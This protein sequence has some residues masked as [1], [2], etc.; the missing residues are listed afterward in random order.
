MVHIKSEEDA[1]SDANSESPTAELWGTPVEQTEVDHWSNIGPSSAPAALSFMRSPTQLTAQSL[2][3]ARP[4]A[5]P[6]HVF[7]SETGAK[8][9]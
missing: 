9:M 8:H 7:I 1:F 3:P 5:I 4:R 2:R 6:A